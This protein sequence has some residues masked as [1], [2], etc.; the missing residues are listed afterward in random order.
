[1]VTF[2]TNS[3]AAPYILPPAPPQHC[4]N[5]DIASRPVHTHLS[6]QTFASTPPLLLNLHLRKNN[7]TTTTFDFPDFSSLNALHLTTPPPLPLLL[8]YLCSFGHFSLSASPFPSGRQLQLV[9]ICTSVLQLLAN[10]TPA[11]IFRRTADSLQLVVHYS[12]P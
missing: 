3:S 2:N 6:Q 8:H 10:F 1:M 7:C 12:Q 9:N 5:A 11:H 4:N